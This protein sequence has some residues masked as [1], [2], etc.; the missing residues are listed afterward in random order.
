MI[1]TA[2]ELAISHG[3]TAACSAV[4]VPRSS[5]YRAWPTPSMLETPEPEQ[6][7]GA[8]PRVR[9]AEA[10]SGGARRSARALSPA[11]QT[12]VREL[13]NSERFQDLAPR[14]VYAELLDQE[15]YLCFDQHDVPH[16]G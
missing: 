15:R 8:R 2:E 1:Q 4:V 9:G 10:R 11:E 3:V 7:A 13:L 14:E 5:L 12:Q 16:P 6:A